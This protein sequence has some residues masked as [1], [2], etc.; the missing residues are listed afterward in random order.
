MNK[1]VILI[2]MIACGIIGYIKINKQSSQHYTT[3]SSGL[4]QPTAPTK[5][6]LYGTKTCGY[7]MQTRQFLQQKNIPYLDIDVEDNPQG[8]KD[9]EAIDGEGVPLIR[10]I[11]QDTTETILRGYDPNQIIQALSH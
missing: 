2:L 11:H 9:Y 8:L 10:V 4:I 3:T 7:C 5:L 6:V 1:I